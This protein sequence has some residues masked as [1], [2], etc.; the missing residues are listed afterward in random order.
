M[1][2]QQQPTREQLFNQE[3]HRRVTS[4]ITDKPYVS[5]IFDCCKTISA[6]QILEQFARLSLKEIENEDYEDMVQGRLT[7]HNVRFLWQ[8]MSGLTPIQLNIPPAT[9]YSVLAESI[10]K[11]E[12]PESALSEVIE[13][14]VLDKI[15]VEI[16]NQFALIEKKMLE[17]QKPGKAVIPNNRR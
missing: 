3:F 9:Y 15:K 11:L 7:Y 13:K 5:A 4:Y 2:Y 17:Q 1:Q 6:N 10:K 8:L 16:N 14:D 12:D